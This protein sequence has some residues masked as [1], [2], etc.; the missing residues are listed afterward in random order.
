LG[1]FRPGRFP[2]TAQSL[3]AAATPVTEDWMNVRNVLIA[4]GAATALASL[5]T[6]ALASGSIS[7]T[8][9]ASVTILSPTNITK[10]QNLVF[11]QV[12]RPS[13]ANANTVTLD[14][15]D[16]VTLT[17][18]GNG[19]VVAS[20]TSSAKFDVS[21]PAGTT[22]STTQSLTFTQTGLTNI[23]ASTPTTTNGAPGVIPA[24]GVQEI[25]YGGQFDMTASTPAQA[26]TGTLSVTVNYN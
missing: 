1:P 14:A 24:S 17:G 19:S 20:T 11:G 3:T 10:T 13:N 18:S 25:R 5:G 4:A 26:Y 9:P 7:T 22:Y 23:A 12:I 8:A 16:T 6:S 21:A 15:N 2:H